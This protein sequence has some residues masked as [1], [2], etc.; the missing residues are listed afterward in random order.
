MTAPWIERLRVPTATKRTGSIDENDGSN[1]AEDEDDDDCPGYDE[2][3]PYSKSVIDP[4]G[5]SYE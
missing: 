5:S 2:D 3:R 4:L 1:G